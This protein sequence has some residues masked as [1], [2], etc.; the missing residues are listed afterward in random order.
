MSRRPAGRGFKNAPRKPDKQIA[1]SGRSGDHRLLIE[2]GKLNLKK[3]FSFIQ[4]HR[5]KRGNAAWDQ[6]DIDLC[7]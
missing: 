4:I 1:L 7:R 2:T 3:N 5:L 6:I